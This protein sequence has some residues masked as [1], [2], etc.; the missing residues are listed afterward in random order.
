MYVYTDRTPR[1]WEHGTTF[2][3][4]T[5]RDLRVDVARR[6][7]YSTRATFL[8]LIGIP[9]VGLRSCFNLLLWVD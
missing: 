2:N 6:R 1:E 3:F 4:T 5:E 7:F 8:D 9:Q